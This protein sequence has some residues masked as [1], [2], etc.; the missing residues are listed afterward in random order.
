MLKKFHQGTLWSL[1]SLKS[2]SLGSSSQC[3]VTCQRGTQQRVLRCAEKYISGKYREL[4]TKKC[5]HLPKPDLELER[6][7]G[8]IPCPK[9][10]PYAA[11]GPPRGSWFAS[12]WSQ[13][14]YAHI[15]RG[16]LP[17]GVHSLKCTEPSWSFSPACGWPLE[18]GC[19]L[20]RID[21]TC[22]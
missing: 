5:L 20:L 12:P 15:G 22:C 2:L 19:G 16:Q 8:L 7:C 21:S 6:A 9:H 18:G 4:A 17:V 14:S 3:S 10:P 13:V 1:I 11:A